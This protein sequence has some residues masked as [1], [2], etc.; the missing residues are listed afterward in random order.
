MKIDPNDNA[1]PVPGLSNL[2]NGDV[3]FPSGGMTIR[4]YMALH[5]AAAYINNGDPTDLSVL[6][7][8]QDADALIAELNK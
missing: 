1:F 4:A 3:V 8:V 5:F 2:P 7:G 6:W